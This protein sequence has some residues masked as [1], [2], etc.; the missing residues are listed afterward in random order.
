MDA[1]RVS[2]ELLRPHAPPPGYPSLYNTA[3]W[4]LGNSVSQSRAMTLSSCND[5]F[6]GNA[7][8]LIHYTQ[9]LASEG[10]AAYFARRPPSRLRNSATLSG[11]SRHRLSIF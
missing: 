2:A 10:S 6:L 9:V 8:V 7:A 11:S 1:L 3:P 5:N 4:C